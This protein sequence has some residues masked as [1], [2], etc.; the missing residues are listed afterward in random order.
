D[1]IAVLKEYGVSQMP[2]FAE[3]VHDDAVMDDVIGS[4]RENDLLD[5]AVSDPKVMGRPVGEVMQ[6]RLPTITTAQTVD[7]AMGQLTGPDSAFL[8]V[9]DGRPTGVLTRTDVLGWLAGVG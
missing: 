1:A 9:E 7:D 4:I 8:I 6:D 2:V 3:G 5:L